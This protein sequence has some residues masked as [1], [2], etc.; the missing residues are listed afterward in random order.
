MVLGRLSARQTA[1]I[2]QLTERDIDPESA[3]SAAIVFNVSQE[4]R[5]QSCWIN[6]VAIQ[7]DWIDVRRDTLC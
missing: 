2:W 1:K 6:H 7:H 3:G 4:L 5:L